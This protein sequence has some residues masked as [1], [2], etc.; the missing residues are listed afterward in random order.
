MTKSVIE[1]DVVCPKCRV[2]C[3]LDKVD[4][5]G[6]YDDSCWQC[7]HKF[8]LIKALLKYPPVIKELKVKH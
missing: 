5:H 8:P 3:S 7:G 1:V 4:K 6:F 2:I